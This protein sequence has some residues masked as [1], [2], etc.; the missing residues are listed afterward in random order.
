MEEALMKRDFKQ[1]EEYPYFD[2]KRNCGCNPCNNCNDWPFPNHNPCNCQPKH[3]PN[4]PP[5]QNPV[6][7]HP[8]QRCSNELLL[9]LSGI[10]VGRYLD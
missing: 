1:Y 8:K 10:I 2:M 9:F 5:C 6:I 4:F 7:T 3:K